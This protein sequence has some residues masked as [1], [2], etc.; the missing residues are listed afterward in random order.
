MLRQIS[1]GQFLEWM[2]YA[3]L[4]P[5]DEVRDDY[6]IAS[7]VQMIA[8]VNR[9]TKKQPKPFPISEFVLKFGATEK[10]PQTWEEQKMLAKMFF[11]AYQAEGPKR[12]R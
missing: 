7:V 2:A 5:F 1:I 8:N 9:D 4:E 10:K 11:S 12:G 6:R 3:E